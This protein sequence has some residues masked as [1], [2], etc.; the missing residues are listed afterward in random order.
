MPPEAP[1]GL[2]RAAAPSLDVARSGA[3]QIGH[4][5]PFHTGLIFVG[6]KLDFAG[7]PERAALNENSRLPRYPL[8]SGRLLQ[9]K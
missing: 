2:Y 1:P 9:E 8:D 7:N 6:L 5:K 3:R 4:T